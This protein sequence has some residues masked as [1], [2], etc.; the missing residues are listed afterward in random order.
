[1]H[2]VSLSVLLVY[3]LASVG[4]WNIAC[5][6]FALCLILMCKYI[7]C[8]SL[9][10]WDTSLRMLFSSS[11]HFRENFKMSL[12]LLLSSIPLCKCTTFYLSI[13][14]IRGISFVSSISLLQLML[15][16]A[17]LSK[18]LCGMSV[19]H[20]FTCQRVVLVGLEVD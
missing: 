9:W 5:L 2:Y 19:D 3:Y 7:P 13:F 18:F 8:L 6:S 4:P 10:V 11:I 17:Q 14:Q 15:L 20:L 16:L 1:M 12:L